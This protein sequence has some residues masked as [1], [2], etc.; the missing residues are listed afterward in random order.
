[1]PCQQTMEGVC[2]SIHDLSIAAIGNQKHVIR[3]LPFRVFDID[4]LVIVANYHQFKL[5]RFC[6]DDG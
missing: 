4:D 5:K 1:M 3:W 2:I 6:I